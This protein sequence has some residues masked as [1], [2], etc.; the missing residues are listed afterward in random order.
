VGGGRPGRWNLIG[1]PHGRIG[2]LVEYQQ[3]EPAEQGAMLRDDRIDVTLR[4]RIHVEP[5]R[6]FP[7]QLTRSHTLFSAAADPSYTAARQ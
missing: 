1:E 2:A 7:P 6:T 3:V 4:C 5:Q